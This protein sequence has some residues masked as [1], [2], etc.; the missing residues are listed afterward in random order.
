MLAVLMMLSLAA[1][2]KTPAEPTQTPS[3]QPSTET[4]TTE[5]TEP[6]PTYA[7]DTLTVGTTA[8][9]CARTCSAG[10]ASLAMWATQ[11]S[12]SCSMLVYWNVPPA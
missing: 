7:I 12:M 3:T 5:A 8:S 4:P 2:G 9:M 6:A 10:Q 1:C 11:K